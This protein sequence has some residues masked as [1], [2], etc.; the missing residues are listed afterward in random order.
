MAENRVLF[1]KVNGA[2]VPVLGGLGGADL[3]PRVVVLEEDMTA[4]TQTVIVPPEEEGGETT[5]KTVVAAHQDETGI[6]GVATADKYG[7]VRLLNDPA[8]ENVSTGDTFSANAIKELMSGR[9]TIQWPDDT[10]PSIGTMLDDASFL[11]TSSGTFTLPAGRYSI[12]LV[13]GGGGG[14]YITSSN[15]RGPQV[16]GDSSIPVIAQ[17]GLNAPASIAVTVGAGG[18]NSSLTYGDSVYVAPAGTPSGGSSGTGISYSYSGGAAGAYSGGH[19]STNMSSTR[20][21]SGGGSGS[22][23]SRILSNVPTAASG[24]GG[25]GACPSDHNW[26]SPGSG[27]RGYGAGGGGG[28]V[29]KSCASG[30]SYNYGSGGAGAPGC[31]LITVLL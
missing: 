14:G 7:H 6:F 15:G 4:I 2:G 27:G 10:V 26:T 12:E 5:S 1:Q 23:L 9:G 30:S 20:Q 13:G 18:G 19:C 25:A 3:E 8:A 24:S 31:I 28:G 21:S 16:G 22:R 11:V 29:C 17:I